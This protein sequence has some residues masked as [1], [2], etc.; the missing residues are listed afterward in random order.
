MLQGTITKNYISDGKN[1]AQIDDADA[2]WLKGLYNDYLNA[3]KEYDDWKKRAYLGEIAQLSSAFIP[4][5]AFGAIGNAALRGLASGAVGGGVFGLGRGLVED[6]NPIKTAVHDAIIGGSVGGALPVAGN[7]AL[8]TK[9]GQ[10]AANK[11]S[12]LADKFAQTKAYDTLMSEFAPIKNWNKQT[13]YHGSPYDFNK[14]SN[15]AIG[16]GEGAQAHGYGHYAAKNKD[17]AEGYRN[18]LGKGEIILYNGES[19][20]YIE[21]NNGMNNAQLLDAILYRGKNGVIKHLENT[22]PFGKDTDE[23]INYV[24]SIDE[25]ALKK[26]SNS[27]LYKL[28]IPKN[29][30]M[31]REDATFAEQPKAVQD[32]LKKLANDY[33]E[34]GYGDLLDSIGWDEKGESLYRLYSRLAGNGENA[35]RE[36]N[37]YGIK[38]I[39]YNGGID[40]ESNVIFN[41]D[42]INIVRKYYNQPSIREQLN[43][44]NKGSLG[45]SAKNAYDDVIENIRRIN[46]GNALN[47]TYS[48]VYNDEIDDVLDL[49][50]IFSEKVKPE[51][52]KNY[53]VELVKEGAIPTKTPEYLIDVPDKSINKRHIQYKNNWERMPREAQERHNALALKLKEM[54]KNSEHTGQPKTNTK[55]DTKKNVKKYH[56]FKVMVKDGDNIFPVILDTEQLIGENEIK[57]QTVHLYNF[58]EKK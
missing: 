30:V 4:V 11:L 12:E 43:N 47:K 52:V 23:L 13:V 25:N 48:G 34:I 16:T 26:Q 24:K 33:K 32:A 7:L 55:L 57:P 2:E 45:A 18:R 1:T 22:R 40:G 3:Q 53:I 35:A 42:D 17:V 9:A 8:K 20:K 15:D 14:F 51:D 31:L 6:E 27:Q 37:N 50:G 54:I 29:D 44:A 19:P 41:P 39:S 28:S 38:G 46:S 56:Y 21:F 5:G 36:L 58:S 49:S 10:A